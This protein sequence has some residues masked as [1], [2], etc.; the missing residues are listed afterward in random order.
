[1]VLSKENKLNPKD[2]A[3]NLKK[4][5]LNNIDHFEKIEIAGPGFLNIKLS[6]VGVIS[7]INEIFKNKD[8]Y[9]SKK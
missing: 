3:T 2:L 4:L 5:L 7:N 6:K 1:M 9:G 8:I